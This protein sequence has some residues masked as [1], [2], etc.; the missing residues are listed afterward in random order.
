MPILVPVEILGEGPAHRLERLS[1][2]T[3]MSLEEVASTLL[4]DA[5]SHPGKP[6]QF[7]AATTGSALAAGSRRLTVPLTYASNQLLIALSL[8]SGLTIP[9]AAGL[10]LEELKPTALRPAIH[11]LFRLHRQRLRDLGTPSNVNANVN[12]QSQAPAGPALSHP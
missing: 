1:H 9:M 10:I 12:A 5:L 6:G 4:E 2:F 11:A 3:G 8:R 7:G